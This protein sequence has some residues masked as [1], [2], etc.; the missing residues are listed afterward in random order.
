MKPALKTANFWER[1]SASKFPYRFPKLYGLVLEY[2]SLCGRILLLGKRGD[3]CQPRMGPIWETSEL[4]HLTPNMR[5]QVRIRDMQQTLSLYPWMSP[6]DWNLFL[7]GWD[8]GSEYSARAGRS[9]TQ[10]HSAC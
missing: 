4:G 8:A 1:L 7:L 6:E 9:D 2:R 10:E 3:V 5:T